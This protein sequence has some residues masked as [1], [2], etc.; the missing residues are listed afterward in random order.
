MNRRPEVVIERG[1]K[2]M[3][4]KKSPWPQDVQKIICVCWC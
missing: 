1:V 2:G 4:A 3:L